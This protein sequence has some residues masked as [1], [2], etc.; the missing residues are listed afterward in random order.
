MRS[1]R[2]QLTAVL[3]LVSL[4]CAL[5]LVSDYDESTDRNLTALQGEVD[6]FLRR[7]SRPPAPACTHGQNSS[8]Y[9]RSYSTVSTLI[10]R[11]RARPKNEITVQQLELLDSSLVT[12]ERLHRL[13]GDVCMTPTETA[14]LRANFQT[15][16]T[17]ILR[18]ELAKRRG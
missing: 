13:K 1:A 10:V 9:D 4:A 11:N 17:A 8:F 7:I 18:L 3:A 6:S 14:P 12:L 16:F 15:S 2:A 5:R